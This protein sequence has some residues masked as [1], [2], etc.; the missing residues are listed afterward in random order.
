MNNFFIHCIS[1]CKECI[2]SSKRKKNNQ[3]EKAPTMH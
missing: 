3:A 1:D 2:E